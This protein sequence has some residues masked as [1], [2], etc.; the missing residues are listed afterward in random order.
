MTLSRD[1]FSQASKRRQLYLVQLK[2]LEASCYGSC[3]SLGVSFRIIIHLR[4]VG[5]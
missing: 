1:W 4:A 5:Y 2:Q 3:S